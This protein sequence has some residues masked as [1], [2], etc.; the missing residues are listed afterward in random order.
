MPQCLSN[1]TCLKIMQTRLFSR[2]RESP[3]EIASALQA[4]ASLEVFSNNMVQDRTW[5]SKDRSTWNHQ[6]AKCSMGTLPTRS[7]GF[8]APGGIIHQLGSKAS[9]R[10]LQQQGVRH[11]DLLFSAHGKSYPLTRGGS[12]WQEWL[13]FW[14]MREELTLGH[15]S[16]TLLCE[17]SNA[18]I[19]YLFSSWRSRYF[20]FCVTIQNSNIHPRCFSPRL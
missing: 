15:W 12:M 7:K 16:S 4:H 14:D 5:E 6:R 9:S 18:F 11:S 19:T 8:A 20:V 1:T 13:M 3:Y 10:Q 2:A 17:K